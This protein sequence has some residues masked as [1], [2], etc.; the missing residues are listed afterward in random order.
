MSAQLDTAHCTRS[1]P[2]KHEASQSKVETSR[3]PTPDLLSKDQDSAVASRVSPP[4]PEDQTKVRN[5]ECRHATAFACTCAALGFFHAAP[6]I[7]RCV[8]LT[9]WFVLQVTSNALSGQAINKNE[10][11]AADKPALGKQPADD[12]GDKPA[13]KRQK[14][15]QD[16]VQ[17][18]TAE[19]KQQLRSTC[20]HEIPLIKAALGK[21]SASSLDAA[22][23]DAKHKADTKLQVRPRYHVWHLPQHCSATCSHE[24][25]AVRRWR[26]CWR[27]ARSP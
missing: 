19:Q 21:P 1:T 18:L 9:P 16:P 22:L 7:D 24:T 17:P 5:S 27:V 8:L 25:H 20:Q 15:E 13:A 10:S 4:V 23:L 3:N 6:N 14:K 11:A 26:S 2:G 12:T